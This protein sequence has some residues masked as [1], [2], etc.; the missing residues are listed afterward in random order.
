MNQQNPRLTPSD[1]TSLPM[2][3]EWIDDD[4]TMIRIEG[5][6]AWTWEDFYRGLNQVVE[7]AR[8]V[9]HRVDLL[10]ARGQSTAPKGGF[11]THYQRA[12]KM[13]PQNV[14]TQV[15]V[16]PSL[17]ART[18]V[19]IMS[20]ITPNSAMRNFMMVATEEEALRAISESR[21]NIS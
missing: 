8:S 3:I 4:K 11:S 13:M 12:L 14:H 21:T 1:Q 5:Q 20:R 16:T 9:P 6:G 2:R 7:M 10:Y 18:V 15:M 19:S 17:F